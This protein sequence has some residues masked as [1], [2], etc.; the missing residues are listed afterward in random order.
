LKTS[1]R[2]HL[3]PSTPHGRYDVTL[4]RRPICF[5]KPLRDI[6]CIHRLHKEDTTS[7]CNEGLYVFEKP[8]H[9]LTC[10]HRL[11]MGDT[12]SHCNG[13][14]NSYEQSMRAITCTHRFHLKDT[15]PHCNGYLYVF[16]KPLRN[17]TCIHRLH[18]EEATSHCN[19]GLYVLKNISATTWKIRR[20]LATEAYMFLIN[21]SATPPACISTPHGSYDVTLQR[22]PICF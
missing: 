6:T 2:H 12:T 7:P 1:A 3:H 17:I 14:H 13:R 16:E 21:L 20:H 10:F 8:L 22:R 19:G 15:T 11:H 18:M 9:N 4:Q 5:E